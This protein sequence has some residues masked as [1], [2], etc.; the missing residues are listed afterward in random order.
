MPDLWANRTCN[1]VPNGLRDDCKDEELV[2][3]FDFSGTDIDGRILEHCAENNEY[4]RVIGAP[5]L[6][7]LERR[8][9]NRTK[10]TNFERIVG[11]FCS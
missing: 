3:N 9:H 8:W 6:V 2:D 11:R 1:V 7:M 5:S 10:S 4:C